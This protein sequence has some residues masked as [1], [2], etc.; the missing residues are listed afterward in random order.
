MN[1]KIFIMAGEASGDLHGAMIVRSLKGLDNHINFYAVG[2]PELRKESV[3]LLYRSAQ[4]E[5]FGVV[6]PL[7]RL[8]FYRRALIDITT[9]IHKEG[10]ETAIL[11]DSPG[12]NLLLARRLKQDGIRVIYYISPQIWAW[13]YSRIKRIK[14]AIDAII[15]LYPFEEEIYRREG[16]KSFFVG[17]P[18][19]DKVME[20]LEKGDS[21]NVKVKKPCICIMPG[22]RISELRRH[23]S[24]MLQAVVKLKQRYNASF[25]I[26][27]L[28]EEAEAFVKEE[29][30]KLKNS[31]IE[32]NLVIDNTYKAIEMADLL[33]VSSGTATL[34]AAIIGKPMVI[35]YKIGLISE[36][37][38]RILVK[39]DHISLVNIVA[40]KRLCPELLQ[41]DVNGERIYEE[42]CKILDNRELYKNMIEDLKGL[43]EKLGQPGAIGRIAKLILSLIGE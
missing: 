10:I 21:I 27:L 36:I 43:K 39:V 2:G 24:P 28:S 20:G 23:L 7:F 29:V 6:E 37:I 26:P 25:L 40:G 38:A 5:A 16:I 17:N 15:V 4:F 19:V 12:F 35:V 33:I 31:E 41:R 8:H 42:A 22:S 14:K 3:F 30:R 13:Y 18:L 32:I 9:F 1:K 11:I 34:E